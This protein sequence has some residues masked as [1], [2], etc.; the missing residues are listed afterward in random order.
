MGRSSY[1]RS[2]RGL[3][4]RLKRY[5]VTVVDNWPHTTHFWTLNGAKKYYNKYQERADLFVWKD[6]AWRWLCGSIVSDDQKGKCR[7]PT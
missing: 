2:L 4:M 1:K 7:E 5:C 6:G 3:I